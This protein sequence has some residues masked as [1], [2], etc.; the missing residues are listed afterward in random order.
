[1]ARHAITSDHLLFFKWPAVSALVLIL[2]ISRP[3][4]HSSVNASARVFSQAAR[5]REALHGVL[6]RR[7]LKPPLR[8]AA[9]WLRFSPD[10]RY[11][12]IQ[13]PA[14]IFLFSRDPL[15]LL[16][17]IEAERVIPA[18][19]S[20]DSQ[21]LRIVSHDLR[22]ATYKI[23]N[24]QGLAFKELPIKDGCLSAA[25]SPDGQLLACYQLDLALNVF[26]L[27]AG[28]E[29]IGN[30]LKKDSTDRLMVPLPLDTDGVYAGPIGYVMVD[31]FA[32]LANRGIP[33]AP[34]AF[35]PDGRELIAGGFGRDNFRMDLQSRKK[36][37]LPELP[38]KHSIAA[39]TWLDRKR[40]LVLEKEKRGGPKIVSLETGAEE[41]S[42]SFVADYVRNSSNPRYLLLY[43]SGSSGARVFD[44]VENHILEVPPNIGVDIQGSEMALF[45]EDGD[46]YLYHLGEK[47]PY[48][49]AHVPVGNL[50]DLRA[51]SLDSTLETLALAVDGQ[52]GVYSVIAG[53][54]IERFTRFL[55]GVF[56]ESPSVFLTFPRS[57]QG[58]AHI[59]RLNTAS[60]ASFEVSSLGNETLRSGGS[61]LFEYSPESPFGKGMVITQSGGISYRLR[62]LDPAS[63]HELWKRS[64]AQESPVPFPDPQGARLVL[65]WKAKSVEARDVARQH[66]AAQ[67]ILKKAKLNEHDTLFEVLDARS[68][69]SLGVALAQVGSRAS[70]FD[71]AFSAGDSLIL[72]KDGFRVS[73]FSLSEGT[74]KAKLVGSKPAASETNDLL[75]LDEG[76]GKLALYDSRTGVKL[77]QLLFP[78]EIAYSHFSPDGGRLFVL[79]QH[80]IAF[81]LDV[82]GIRRLPPPAAAPT[83]P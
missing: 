10:G 21:S 76:A 51:A 39:L 3:L 15:K 81:V 57:A 24:S 33:I 28:G 59:V 7:P 12:F 19:F 29:I 45:I 74:L 9:V 65:G 14:G 2:S 53:A 17:Y 4:A 8:S 49:M 31:S 20:P 13:D 71:A 52:G 50:P 82:S 77:D 78:E 23:E 40:V 38:K 16:G 11:L 80:Q 6:S 46:I 32:P 66:P 70:S 60:G 41:S 22:F 48:R 67:Q 55:T 61:S 68:G 5:P 43:D 1:M 62:A 42:P 34:L 44:L 75:V 79:T 63:G 36:M 25:I 27:A 26:D 83:R 37:S 72:L 64:F 35:S 54:R 56:A 18:S 58:P 69:K 73:L 30:P 47:L